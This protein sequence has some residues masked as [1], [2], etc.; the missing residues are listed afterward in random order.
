MESIHKRTP[1]EAKMKRLVDGVKES[2]E[3][4]ET[5]NLAMVDIWEQT[6]NFLRENYEEEKLEQKFENFQASWDK[7]YEKWGNDLVIALGEQT[8]NINFVNHEGFLDKKTV[9][10]LVKDVRARRRRLNEILA[11]RGVS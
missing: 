7:Q 10:E 11:S 2:A 9:E 3:M 6:I 4:M 1:D 5:L 8:D